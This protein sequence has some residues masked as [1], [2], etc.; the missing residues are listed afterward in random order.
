MSEPGRSERSSSA[1]QTGQV[2]TVAA[3]H[4]VH[5]LYSSFLAPW[6]PLLIEKMSLSLALAGSLTLF[7]RL[8]SLLNPVIGVVADRIEVRYVVIAAPAVT[9]VCMSLIGLAPDYGAVALL[10]FLVG[11]SAAAFH[12]PAPVMI[13]RMSGAQLGKG[14]SCFMA[15]GELARTV[16]PLVAV[17]AVALWGFEGSYPVMLFGLVASALLYWRLRHVAVH[18]RRAGGGTSVA[19]TWRA[20]RHVLVPLTCLVVARALMVASLTTFLPTFMAVSGKSLWVGGTALAVL[21]FSGAFGSLTSGTLSDRLGRRFVLL[22][23]MLASPCLMFIFLVARASAVFAVLVLLGFSVFAAAPVMLAVVQ[24]HAQG[25]RATANGLFMA[26][27]FVVLSTVT[28]LVGWMGDMMGLR[29]A[30]AWSAVL[31]LAGVP[32][33]FLLPK[34]TR[35]KR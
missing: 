18:R 24:E 30:F 22:A 9:A 27:D 1:F 3:G 2:L 7:I 8:P 10:L 25:M 11:V 20:M 31:A 19:K 32:A 34:Q 33:I 35:E 29:A 6:L 26:I 12:V 4:F 13:V 23:S 5:D 17:A 16:G 15:A 21:E 14:M 28:V